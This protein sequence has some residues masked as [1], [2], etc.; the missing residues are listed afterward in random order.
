[1]DGS[2]GGMGGSGYDS[3]D[4]SYGSYGGG[5]GG[6][7]ASGGMGAANAAGM[8]MVPMMLPN[9]QVAFTLMSPP[10]VQ[11]DR[12][13]YVQHFKPSALDLKHIGVQLGQKTCVH[14]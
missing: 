5:M 13:R 3:Y 2:Y 12:L 4:S 7:S 8:A 11:S 6:M 10:S 1:M 9:G 14:V